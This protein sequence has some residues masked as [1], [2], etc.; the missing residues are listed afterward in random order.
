VRITNWP[1]RDDGWSAWAMVAAI[2]I[3][4]LLVG[5]ISSSV[6]VGLF[7]S[8]AFAVSLWRLFVPVTFDFGSRGIVQT[9]RKGRRRIPWNHVAR[10]GVLSHGV[11]LSPDPEQTALA[12][13]RSTYVRWNDQR[14]ELIAVLDF[15][16]NRKNRFDSTTETG[17]P[18]GPEGPQKTPDSTAST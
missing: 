16:L 1:L 8:A 7:T 13:L 6:A 10:Y 9:L 4:G 12:P 2:P 3:V 17:E 15:Y 5:G 11:L 14:A 18:V